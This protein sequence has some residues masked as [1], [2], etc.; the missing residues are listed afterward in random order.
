M[1]LWKSFAITETTDSPRPKTGVHVGSHD[2][3]RL[4]M[5]SGASPL[6]MQNQACFKEFG[7]ESFS[8]M[9][10]DNGGAQRNPYQQGTCRSIEILYRQ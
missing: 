10:K 1:D 3:M 5:I 2:G 8:N 9:I 7:G 4:S 6:L